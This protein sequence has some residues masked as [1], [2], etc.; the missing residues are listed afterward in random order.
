MLSDPVKLKSILEA[1]IFSAEEPLSLKQLESL[2]EGSEKLKPEQLQSLLKGLETDYAD[3]GI[4]LKKTAS[5]YRFQTKI[6][7]NFWLK[8]LRIERPGKYSQAFLETLALIA[9][10]QPITRAEIEAVRG[11]AVNPN[12]IRTLFERE[13]IKVAGYSESPGKPELLETTSAFLDYFNLTSL[14]ELPPLP[15][16]K[17]TTDVESASTPPLK[18]IV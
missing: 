13:W 3:R 16:I 14:Q 4:I 8:R 9:Y 17:N 1:A 5:G 10:R 11:V 2:F 18:Q 12:I 15:E 6:E 7:F